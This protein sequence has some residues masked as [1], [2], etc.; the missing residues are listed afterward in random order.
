MFVQQKKKS[1]INSSK[2][3]TKFCLNLYY[4]GDESYFHVN[5]TEICRFKAS[6]NVG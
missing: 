1:N 5:K 6:D 2:A 3:N 4:N